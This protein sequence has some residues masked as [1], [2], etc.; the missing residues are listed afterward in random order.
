M[1]FCCEISTFL[2]RNQKITEKIEKMY[3]QNSGVSIR[4]STM[5][6]FTDLSIGSVKYGRI[7]MKTLQF[8]Y[9]N[10]A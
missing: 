6:Q 5:E 1:L 9:G 2:I 3:P 8:H 7:K 4:H 10:C